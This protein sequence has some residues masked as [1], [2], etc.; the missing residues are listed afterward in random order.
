[1]NTQTMNHNETNNTMGAGP[2]ATQ[3][4]PW[5]LY[6]HPRARVA[7]GVCGGLGDLLGVDPLLV[8]LLWVVLTFM[9]AGAGFMAYLLLWLFLPVG[10]QAGGAERSAAI[11]FRGMTSRRLAT[12]FMVLGGLWLLSNLGI[13]PALTGVLAVS[14]RLF[15]WPALFLGVGYLIWRGVRGDAGRSP[16]GAGDFV[17]NLSAGM[18]D[19][20]AAMPFRRSREDRLLL[21]VCAGLG[22]RLGVDPT[23][24]RL[25]WALLTL[26]TAG[27]GLLFYLVAA[28]LLPEEET[29]SATA[30]TEPVQDVAIV[31]EDIVNL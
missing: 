5:M 3:S 15:F 28:L 18:R 11:R 2:A 24:V 21:G 16:A 4:A 19:L 17:E 29:A 31:N 6:R 7:G 20:G 22:R 27:A 9:T 1:M 13:L 12:L 25:A 26:A 30:E 8:R 14:A 23:L 10:T